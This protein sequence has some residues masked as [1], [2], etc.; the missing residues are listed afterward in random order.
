MSKNY[1]LSTN[2]KIFV[3]NNN[4]NNFAKIDCTFENIKTPKNMSIIYNQEISN[5]EFANEL[6]N[7][8]IETIEQQL[9]ELYK[10]KKFIEEMKINNKLSLSVL[11]TKQKQE[12][13]NIK[14]LPFLP[15]EVNELI[16][17]KMNIFK[18]DELGEIYKNMIMDY[19]VLEQYRY[20]LHHLGENI[21]DGILEEKENSNFTFKTNW[22]TSFWGRFEGIDLKCENGKWNYEILVDIEITDEMKREMVNFVLDGFKGWDTDGI[23]KVLN[24]YN[25]KND[26]QYIDKKQIQR[27]FGVWTY[28]N[29]NTYLKK[30]INSII[31]YSIEVEVK[32][33]KYL[34]L[35]NDKIK[36]CMNKENETKYWNMLFTK[37]DNWNDIYYKVGS[38]SDYR[39][40]GNEENKEDDKVRTYCKNFVEKKKIPIVNKNGKL[41]NKTNYA[42]M[43]YDICKY[44]Q[45][46][47]LN[48]RYDYYDYDEDGIRDVAEL[49][50]RWGN[51]DRWFQ[52]CNLTEKYYLELFTKYYLTNNGNFKE[53]MKYIN[54][55]NDSILDWE[56]VDNY[57]D[58]YDVDL[59]C[60][61]RITNYNDCCNMKIIE[62]YVRYDKEDRKKCEG[63]K[64]RVYEMYRNKIK[65]R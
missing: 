54:V 15:K 53:Y 52:I 10:Q 16:R 27:N 58:K 11:Y 2:K 48:M 40:N 6:G 25:M 18:Y 22:R 37:H 1:Q 19:L 51:F 47:I 26:I 23:D 13:I 64:N 31:Q 61:G 65:T 63:I 59:S 17:S 35:I 32:I 5:L 3:N 49:F 28:I 43:G 55:S 9:Q 41:S 39:W 36:K 34:N 30:N 8:N 7:K 45:Y 12:N 56:E 24:I 20:G 29:M 33:Y 60:I 14:F 46:N 4:N 62:K 42:I 38:N 21:G 57:V 44:F 50:N